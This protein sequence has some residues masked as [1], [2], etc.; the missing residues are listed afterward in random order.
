MT[1]I[2]TIIKHILAN[3]HSS[4]DININ[5][6]YASLSTVKMK[7]LNVLRLLSFYMLVPR[8]QPD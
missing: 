7:V 3:E 8:L 1:L 4:F 2:S 6:I 5:I